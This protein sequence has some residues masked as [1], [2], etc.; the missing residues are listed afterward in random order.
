MSL[1]ELVLVDFPIRFS[2]DMPKSFDFCPGFP[3][4]DIAR[5]LGFDGFTNDLKLA[6]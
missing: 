2:F 4:A 1:I 6:E 5:G 3:A